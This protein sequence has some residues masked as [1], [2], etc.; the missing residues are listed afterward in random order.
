M[1]VCIY[2]YIYIYIY[3]CVYIEKMSNTNYTSICEHDLE[4]LSTN[5]VMCYQVSEYI[6]MIYIT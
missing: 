3:M 2:I 5:V 6:N 1:C 4:V